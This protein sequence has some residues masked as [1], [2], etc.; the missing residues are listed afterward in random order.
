MVYILPWYF[1]STSVVLVWLYNGVLIFVVKLFIFPDV[2]E[3]L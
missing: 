2:L 3:F 1:H